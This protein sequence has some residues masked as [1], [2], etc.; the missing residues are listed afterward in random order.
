[1]AAHARLADDR[2]VLDAMVASEDGREILRG[3]L[4]GAAAE[5]E[6]LGRRLA[7][8]LLGRGAAAVC[9]LNPAMP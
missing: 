9:A 5:A 8:T 2:L 4:E 6:T 1:M 7:E 3:R